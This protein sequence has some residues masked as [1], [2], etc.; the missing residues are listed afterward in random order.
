M[1][2]DENIILIGMPGVG[3]STVGV[4][5]AKATGRH[6]LDTDVYI[7]VHRGRRLQDILDAEGTAAFCKIEQGHILELDCRST[8]IATGGSVV[9]SPSAMA[10]LAAGGRVVYLE[11][12]VEDII[13]RV[14]DL[15]TRGLVMEPG[16]T[17]ETLYQNRRGLYER[18][19]QIT[20]ECRGLTQDQVVSRILKRL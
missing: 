13:R 16:Q 8:V 7:Q 15:D 1:T 12:P 14:D 2:H 6:F 17:L 5:L 20:I 18:Y 11:L 4:L 10:H 19:A 9:Y 3:K